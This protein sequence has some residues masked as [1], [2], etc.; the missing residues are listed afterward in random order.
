MKRFLDKIIKT[1]TCWNWNG[2]SRGNGYGC[3]RFNGKAVDSHR[4][5]YII[6][7]GEIPKGLCVCHTCDNRMCVNP[8]HLFLGT[9][10][11]NVRDCINKKRFHYSKPIPFAKNH[12]PKNM[13]YSIEV[14][15]E[16]KKMVIGRGSKSLKAIATDNNVSYNFVKEISC[17]RILKNIKVN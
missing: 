11:D 8:E 9:Q 13:K 16:I 14:A 2:G 4:V 10:K 15:T 12:I 17:G 5:S 3:I 7:K 1:D 6:Y